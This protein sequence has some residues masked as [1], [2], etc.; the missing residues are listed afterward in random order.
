M[1]GVN[2]PEQGFW[3]INDDAIGSVDSGERYVVA[4]MHGRL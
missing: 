3:I 1:G 2:S 4:P